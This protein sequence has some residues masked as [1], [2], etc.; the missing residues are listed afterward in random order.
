M[1]LLLIVL[2]AAV[3]IG[4]G[5]AHPQSKSSNGWPV[6]FHADQIRFSGLQPIQALEV[7][8]KL[9]NASLEISPEVKSLHLCSEQSSARLLS[10]RLGLRFDSP[11]WSD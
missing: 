11:Q 8:A 10:C 9:T 2:V 5:R 3:M 7:Y 6:V 1:K 4:C